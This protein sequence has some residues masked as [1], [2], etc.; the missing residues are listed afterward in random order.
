MET[1]KT[2][3]NLKFF[4]WADWN[5]WHFLFQ[6]LF[7]PN[8]S[9]NDLFARERIDLLEIGAEAG[10]SVERIETNLKDA[11]GIIS[12]WMRKNVGGSSHMKAL[13]IQR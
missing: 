5:E 13:R 4:P 2:S 11:L 6:S 3:M 10:I 1:H 12:R 8:L 7:P 9:L